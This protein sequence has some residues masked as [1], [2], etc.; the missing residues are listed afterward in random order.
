MIITETGTYRLLTE[1]SSR[2]SYSIIR[3]PRGALLEITQVHDK[4]VIGPKLLDWVHWDLPV[5]E[6]ANV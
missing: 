5:E 6:V 3:F 1:V 2:G 4:K